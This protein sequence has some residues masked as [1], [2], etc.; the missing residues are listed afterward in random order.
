MVL[1]VDV[2]HLLTAAARVTGHGEDLAAR[3]LCADNRI[4]SAATGWAGRS[5][6]A[7]HNRAARWVATS[8]ALVTR[9]GEQAAGLHTGAAAFAAMEAANTAALRPDTVRPEFTDGS[10]GNRIV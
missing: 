4:E 2:E 5:A 10:P 9:L 1:R 6:T 3:H 7:L 8:T